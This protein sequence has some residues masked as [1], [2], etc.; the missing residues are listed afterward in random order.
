MGLGLQFSSR[1]LPVSSSGIFVRLRVAENA[2]FTEAVLAARG[3]V[4]AQARN[5]AGRCAGIRAFLV[6]R[7]AGCAE[8]ALGYLLFRCSPEL[9]D[10]YAGCAEI[11]RRLSGA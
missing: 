8:M 11:L 5:A 3:K 9:C 4:R 7:G 2:F 1:E 6:V 10:Q